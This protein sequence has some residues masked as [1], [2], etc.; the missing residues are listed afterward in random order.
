MDH[1]EPCIIDSARRHGIADDDIRHAF[2]N[3]LRTFQVADDM[4]L[5][6]GP[7]HTGRLLELG[8]VDSR[9]EPGLVVVHAMP[10]RDK[11][12]RR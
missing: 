4:T 12:L 7:D 3:T 8:V 1:D 9:T 11:F 10:A 5:L 6:I 2:R